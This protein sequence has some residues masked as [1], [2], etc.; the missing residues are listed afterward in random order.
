MAKFK[1][2]E[3]ML[4]INIDTS[5]LSPQQ[6]RLIKTIIEEIHHVCTTTDEG[7]FFDGSADLMRMCAAIIKQGT[8]TSKLKID[9]IPYAE[10][11]LEYSMDAINDC[12]DTTKIVNYDN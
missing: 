5:D 12:V 4:N 9:G 10:Q 3:N 8:F 2:E 7:E 1:H 6:T 11:A